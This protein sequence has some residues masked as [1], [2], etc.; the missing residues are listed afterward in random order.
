MSRYDQNDF[1]DYAD[2]QSKIQRVRHMYVENGRGGNSCDGADLL[3]LDLD[4]L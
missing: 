2:L 1:I 4:V 3:T